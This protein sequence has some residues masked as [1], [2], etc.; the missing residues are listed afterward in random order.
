V[1]A[2]KVVV[3]AFVLAAVL[4][5]LGL[6]ARETRPLPIATAALGISTPK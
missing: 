5:W 3:L 6:A 1:L 4:L 2:A